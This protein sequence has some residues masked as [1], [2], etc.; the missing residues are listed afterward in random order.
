MLDSAG[1]QTVTAGKS[2]VSIG[3]VV[4]DVEIGVLCQSEY[5]FPIR[6]PAATKLEITIM[7]QINLP[8]FV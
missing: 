3:R 5:D 4:M 7:V 8:T 6:N 1:G 2:S